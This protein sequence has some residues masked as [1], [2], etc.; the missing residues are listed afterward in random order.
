MKNKLLYITY[1]GLTDQ[2]ANSQILPYLKI[3][4]NL[5]EVSVLSCEKKTNIYKINKI[6]KYLNKEKI[7][8]HYLYFSKNRFFLL[9]YKIYDF[10]KIYFYLLNL[11]KRN[12]IKIIH[13]RGHLPAFVCYFISFFY[14]IKYIFDFRGRWIEERIDN[15]SLNKETYFGKRLYKFLKFLEKKTINNAYKTIVLTKKMKFFLLENYNL[16]NQ[17]IFVMPC[18]VNINY[19][20]NILLE[21]DLNIYKTLNIPNS[22]KIICYLGSIGGFY[23]M[24]QMISFFSK[25]KK[26]YPEYYFLIITNHI[27][28]A[29]CEIHKIKEKD[30]L[31]NIIVKSLDYEEV[32]LFLSK[33]NLSLFF[34]KE[35]PA[36]IGT[37]PIKFPEFLALGV[38]VICNSNIGDMDLYFKNNGIGKCIDIK[39]NKNI[40]KII[41]DIKNIENLPKNYIKNY[42]NK[43]FSINL[44]STLYKKLYLDIL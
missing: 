16:Q 1:D 27:K 18:Y 40:D 14:D 17:N 26:K 37:F 35:S 23:L 36:R 9:F 32:P 4:N 28:Q 29:N 5:F 7:N 8:Y 22:S 33:I 24:E 44:A 10:L 31:D 19:F 21:K 38:P 6:N 11:L 25:L 20:K 30:I 39:N 43:K 12:K 13:A 2:L 34:L 42:A 41:D 3:L 15:H